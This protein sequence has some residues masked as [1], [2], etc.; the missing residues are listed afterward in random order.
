MNAPVSSALL[1][2]LYPSLLACLILTGIHAYLGMH[3]AERGIVFA[4]LALPQLA[5]LGTTLA[6][7]AGYDLHSWMTY[8]F[9]LGLTIAGAVILA[10]TRAQEA[11]IGTVYAVA[12]AAAVLAISHAPEATEHLKEILAGDLLTVSKHAVAETAA[13]Y[14]AV[15]IV[16]WIVRRRLT[17]FAFYASLAVVVTSSVAIAGVLVVFA[18]LVAPAV[19]ARLFTRSAGKR[20][21]IGWT[22][23]AV[24]SAIGILLSL[25]ADV[26]TGATIVCT[27]G[28]ALLLLATVSLARRSRNGRVC[29]SADARPGLR[30]G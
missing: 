29:K 14:A 5:A 20:L 16:H 3:L 25:W 15:G 30:S 17:D 28:I 9:S 7:L 10:F 13:I 19:A 11:V 6:F 12:A 21:A 26:P 8:A 1:G 27:F 23:G 4:A 24:V 18:Y 2:F 22:M